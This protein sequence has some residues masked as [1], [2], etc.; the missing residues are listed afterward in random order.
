MKIYL[1]SALVL[2]TT[3]SLASDTVAVDLSAFHK[4][5]EANN[6][7]IHVKKSESTFDQLELNVS[8]VAPS[9]AFNSFSASVNTPMIRSFMFANGKL[10]ASFGAGMDSIKREQGARQQQI[11]MPSLRVGGE[12]SLGLPFLPWVTPYVSAAVLPTI[13]MSQRSSFR[14]QNSGYGFPLEYGGGLAV[15]LNKVNKYITD[16]A[17]NLGFIAR[18]GKVEKEDVGG[19]GV[20]IGVRVGI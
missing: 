9:G 2:L 8:N 11:Y 4:L 13:V 15:G 7:S 17:L 18:S 19:T 1:L 6:S 16:A 14:D 5:A 20:L 10:A 12:Y 3:S